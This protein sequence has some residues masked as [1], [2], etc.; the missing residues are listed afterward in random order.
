MSRS[1]LR[2][3]RA[4][5]GLL[6]A[7]VGAALGV[8]GH[9]LAGGGVPTSPALV[10]LVLLAAGACTALSDREWSYP[11]LLTAMAG[12]EAL[13]HLGMS[14]MGHG[15][16]HP[17]PSG[18]VMLAG[19]AA[20]AVVTAWVLRSGEEMF[21]RAVERLRPRPIWPTLSARFDVRLPSVRWREDAEPQSLTQLLSSLSRRGPPALT[22][23]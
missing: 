19:H 11:R 6:V 3:A 18:W 14:S 16:A 17:G 8:G 15:A 23:V 4:V 10:L 21:W 7:A 22:A 1:A 20:A 5:R 12:L 9:L 13:V 2:R